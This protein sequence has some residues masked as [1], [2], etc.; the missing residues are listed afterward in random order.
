[1]ALGSLRDADHRVVAIV[2]VAVLA[3]ACAGAFAVGRFHLLDRGYTMSGEFTD[4][5]G[6]KKGQDVRVAGVRAGRVTSVR[7]DFAHGRVVI[8]WHVD[9]GIDLGPAT[10]A[11]IR[12]TTLLGGRYLRLSGPVARPYMAS[13][14]EPRRRIPPTRTGVPFTVPDAL[15]GTQHVVGRLDKKSVDRL[16]T[17]VARIKAPGSAKLRSVLADVQSL[18]RMLNDSHPDVQRLIEDSRTITGTLAGKDDELR[19]IIDSS[20]VL[21]RTLVERRDELAAT[22]GKGSRTVRTL[23]DV[24]SRNQRRLDDLLDDLHLLTTRLAPN[25]DALNTDFSLLGPTFQ[26]VATLKGNGPWIEGMLTGLG[27][28]QPPGPISTRRPPGGG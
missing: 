15:E 23:S 6:L 14:P 12:T 26:Q 5:A 9:A 1:M 17:E 19:G 7:P 24:I 3:A 4:T 10:R 21:L 22:I 8:T 28:I 11:E 27:P 18:S 16:L 20:Q 13:V 2:T 25:M